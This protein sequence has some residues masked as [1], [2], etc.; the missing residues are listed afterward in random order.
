MLSA[1][2]LSS[3]GKSMD[4]GQN[5]CLSRASIRHFF[6]NIRHLFWPQSRWLLAGSDHWPLWWPTPLPSAALKFCWPIAGENFQLTSLVSKPNNFVCSI[7]FGMALHRRKLNSVTGHFR[8][9]ERTP[10]LFP[11]RGATIGRYGGPHHYHRR[12]LSSV[13]QS[14]VKDFRWPLWEVNPIILFVHKLFNLE[15]LQIGENE[16]R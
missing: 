10:W 4:C 13:G 8:A 6:D 2:L 14:Q 1:V 9:S 7:Q 3:F 16:I 11:A 12:C 5:I 15:W